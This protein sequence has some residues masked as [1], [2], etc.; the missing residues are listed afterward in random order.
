MPSPVSTYD[1]FT[2]GPSAP[3][4]KIGHNLGIYS[5]GAYRFFRVLYIEGLPPS[6]QLT[7]NLGAITAGS[8]TSAIEITVVNAQEGSLIQARA[9]VV[10]DIEVSLSQVRGTGRYVT[11]TQQARISLFTGGMDP[12]HAMTT[13]FIIGKNRQVYATGYNQTDYDAAQAR[14]KFWGYRYIIDRLRQEQ[15]RYLQFVVLNKYEELE[16]ELKARYKGLSA[17]VVAAEGYGN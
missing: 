2:P 11:D 14:V 6:P 5:Q 15:E 16:D 10:D 4:C 13:M 1:P 9:A 3:A 17:T 12:Y 7:Q 8:S